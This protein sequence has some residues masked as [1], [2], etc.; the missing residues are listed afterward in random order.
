[1]R[2]LSCGGNDCQEVLPSQ[3]P[4]TCT[5]CGVQIPFKQFDSAGR[6]PSC[7]TY[8]IRDNMVAYPYGPD[9]IIP[10]KISKRE[11]EEKLKNEFG[12]KLFL[13]DSFLSEKTLESMRGV[14]VPFWMYDYNSNIDYSAVGTK[15]RTWTSGDRRYTETSY[16]N[17]YRKLHINYDGIPVDASVEMADDIMDLLEP[18]NYEQLLSH[19]NKFISG[20]NAETYNMPPNQLEPRA[21]KK[22]NKSNRE[23]IAEY[24]S[25]YS[26]LS[27]EH[28]NMD[29]QLLGN[30][31]ALLPVWV[32][33][34]RYQG[35]NYKFYVNGETGKCVGKA[36]LSVGK[37]VGLTALLLVSAFVGLDGLSMLL[38]VL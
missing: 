4:D 12:K 15:V 26:S 1:M 23:W 31:F 3:T 2:C 13:P 10:F 20:F 28:C 19:D 35:T 9:I 14:Y 17:V 36:P 5:N 27:G 21:I 30:K 18:Y 38:G 16:Y 33:E 25:G 37:A 24:T 29:N 6:C 7:G 32:Y 22:V 34:Y 11:A 8:I